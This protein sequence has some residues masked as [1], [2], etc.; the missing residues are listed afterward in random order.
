[1]PT[2]CIWLADPPFYPAHAA[3]TAHASTDRP[4]R[5]PSLCLLV[6]A[7][8][9]AGKGLLDDELLGNRH[10]QPRGLSKSLANLRNRAD[11]LLRRRWSSSNSAERSYFKV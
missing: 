10:I 4:H 7:A 6:L 9:I 2:G 3:A 1:M 11:V 8:A 5:T